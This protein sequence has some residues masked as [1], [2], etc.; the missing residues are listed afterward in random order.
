MFRRKLRLDLSPI[1]EKIFPFCKV[2]EDINWGNCFNWALVVKRLLHSYYTV[3]LYNDS[4]ESHAFVKIRDLY[5]DSESPRGVKSNTKLH[6]H[7]HRREQYSKL[8]PVHPLVFFNFWKEE[9]YARIWSTKEIDRK[10]AK[11]GLTV[12]DLKA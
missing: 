10:I 2:P 8:T 12:D 3:D 5:F 7:R 4:N 1:H 6:I 9:G 11:S